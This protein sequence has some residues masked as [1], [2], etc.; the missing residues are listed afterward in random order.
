MSMKNI[1]AAGLS[2]LLLCIAGC[3]SY[4]RFPANTSESAD[5][6]MRDFGVMGEHIAVGLET[7]RG[8][9]LRSEIKTFVT[10]KSTN[11]RY[12]GTSGRMFFQDEAMVVYGFLPLPTHDKDSRGY[13]ADYQSVRGVIVTDLCDEP[14]RLLITRRKVGGGYSCWL[15]SSCVS[16]TPFTIWQK[17]DCSIESGN[18]LRVEGR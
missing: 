17:W 8:N 3:A 13:V 14:E 12:F 7:L 11:K 4:P 6:L 2:T 15:R 10:D 1:F 18:T 5:E 9:T 16:T